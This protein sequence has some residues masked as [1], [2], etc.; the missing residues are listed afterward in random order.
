MLMWTTSPLAALTPAFPSLLLENLE[1]RPPNQILNVSVG[2]V[3]PR[4]RVVMALINWVNL[5]IE[6]AQ[7]ISEGKLC[8]TV[9]CDRL[10]VI[11][12]DRC[13]IL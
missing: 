10:F 13:V 12:P 7:P 4:R 11:T 5:L 2:E 3:R 6:L 9:V 1:E 8:Q